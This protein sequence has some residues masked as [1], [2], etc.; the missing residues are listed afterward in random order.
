[1]VAAGCLIE[2]EDVLT[3]THEDY[4]V[5]ASAHGGLVRA[6][7]ID[8]TGAVDD[9]RRV[10]DTE[11]AV[12]AALGRLATGALLFGSMLKEP[13]HAVSVRVL[14]DGPAGALL[15]TATGTGEVRGL[16]RNAQTGIEQVKE[17][18]KLNVSG[19]VGTNGRLTVTR[20]FGMRHPYVGV[21]QL[22]SGEIGEDLAHYLRSSE[23]TP[24]AVGL[25]VFV[26][27]TGEVIAAGG[28]IVQL[29]PGVADRTAAEIDEAIRG[30]PH[31]TTMLRDG[32][33]PET[34][35][36]RIFGDDFEV[37]DRVPVRFHCPCSRE[38]VERALMLLGEAELRSILEKDRAVGYTE[39][40]CEFCTTR[41]ELSTTDVAGLI[42]SIAASRVA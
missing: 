1:L 23:Q 5:R 33:T 39:V 28:Y 7:A 18:G 36:S 9:L 41:Y 8:A 32:D 20:D 16:V 14:G 34:V 38:R 30:L 4:L 24:S 19:V 6:F 26:R 15:A 27:R 11:P 25:G 37:L 22:V 2:L 40:T 10:H 21:V 17:N 12:T 13:G 42:A 29:L 35:L 3:R 31:P